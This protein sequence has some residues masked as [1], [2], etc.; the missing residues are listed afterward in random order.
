MVRE[1]H[2]KQKPEQPRE[3]ES[4]ELKT[5]DPTTRIIWSCS[6]CDQYEHLRNAAMHQTEIHMTVSILH[7]PFKETAAK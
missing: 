1:D 3:S 4:R 2:T 5:K 6:V 7:I